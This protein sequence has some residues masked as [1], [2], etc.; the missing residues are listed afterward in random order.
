MFNALKLMIN[1]SI[2][3]M[4]FSNLMVT[5]NQNKIICMRKPDQLQETHVGKGSNL[6]LLAV[7]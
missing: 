1:V 6:N 5:G 2:H 3:L 4:A 7:R